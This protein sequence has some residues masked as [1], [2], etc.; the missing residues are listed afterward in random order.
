MNFLLIDNTGTIQHILPHQN[1]KILFDQRHEQYINIHCF[2]YKRI[3][4]KNTMELN[5]GRKN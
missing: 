1:H 5:Q 3:E 2:N 4:C